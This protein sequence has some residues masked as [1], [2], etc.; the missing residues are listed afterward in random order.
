M[1]TLSLCAKQCL[2]RALGIINVESD[3]VVVPEV[4]FG[5]VAL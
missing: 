3:P 5:Q 4:E 1:S 2:Y